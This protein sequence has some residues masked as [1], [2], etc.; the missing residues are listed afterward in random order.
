MVFD[1]VPAS[2]LMGAAWV[3]L[4]DLVPGDP[5]P[6]LIVNLHAPAGCPSP[7]RLRVADY[8]ASFA[9]SGMVFPTY[10]SVALASTRF[11]RD[12]S[13]LTPLGS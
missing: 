6:D 3:R 5:Q 4:G 10:A 13:V 1:V 12:V 11:V 8:V 7:T 9:G 2:E